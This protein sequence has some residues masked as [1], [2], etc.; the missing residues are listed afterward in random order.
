MFDN[1]LA[2]VLTVV[3]SIMRV[4]RNWRRCFFVLPWKRCDVK[5]LPDFKPPL[6]VFLKRFA[7]ARCVLNLGIDMSSKLGL[8][9]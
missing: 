1:I 7:E 5:A 4:P 6:A 2:Y 9:T 8:I 3:E